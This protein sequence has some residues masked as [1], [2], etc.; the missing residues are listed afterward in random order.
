[1]LLAPSSRQRNGSM[2]IYA[3]AIHA[4]VERACII[5]E[6]AAFPERLFDEFIM[7]NSNRLSVASELCQHRYHV[8]R[9]GAKGKKGANLPPP[10]AS[11]AARSGRQITPRLLRSCSPPPRSHARLLFR[12]PAGEVARTATGTAAEGKAAVTGRLITCAAICG[13][14][15]GILLRAI[16]QARTQTSMLVCPDV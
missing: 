9:R 8:E 6:G 10:S 15:V 5:N 12:T 2:F 16:V 7:K 11:P 14:P 4:L 13:I 1:M 3:T